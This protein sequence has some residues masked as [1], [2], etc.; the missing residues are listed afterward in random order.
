MHAVRNSNIVT[1]IASY[2]GNVVN[3]TLEQLKRLQ[4]DAKRVKLDEWAKKTTDKLIEKRWMTN[5]IQGADPALDG[6]Y[7]EM[8]HH[9]EHGM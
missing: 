3:Y 7:R 8:R 2:L 4:D 6:F 9:G 1:D 5:Q